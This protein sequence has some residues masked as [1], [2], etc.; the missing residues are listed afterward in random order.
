MAA[1]IGRYEYTL[2]PKHR[3]FIPPRYRDEL[4]REKGPHFFISMGLDRC[5]YLFLPSQWER[6]VSGEERL[7]LRD[8][9]QQR[10]VKRMIFG[11]ASEAPTDEQGRILIP[12]HL[13][14]FARLKKDVIVVGSG[15]RAELWDKAA[16]QI[17]ERI[18]R[19]ILEKV[20]PDLDL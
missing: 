17:Q 1:L 9:R 8:K 16:F 4:T 7:E 3:V 19:K 12:P 10:S 11:H 13:V 6:L 20:S 5:L 15:K 14:E 18:G 2:D